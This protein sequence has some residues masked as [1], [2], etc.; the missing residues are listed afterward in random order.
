M[1]QSDQVFLKNSKLHY[2]SVVPRI[3]DGKHMTESVINL[4]SS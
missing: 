2:Y 3:Q 1:E 4:A